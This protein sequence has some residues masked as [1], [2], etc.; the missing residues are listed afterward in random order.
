MPLDFY[1]VKVICRGKVSKKGKPNHDHGEDKESYKN[2]YC[3]QLKTLLEENIFRDSSVGSVESEPVV[4]QIS[5][6]VERVA[7]NH[8]MGDRMQRAI[9]ELESKGTREG[10]TSN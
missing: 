1:D 10:P 7:D 3:P 2:I 8:L 6:A 5:M 4:M 9:Q